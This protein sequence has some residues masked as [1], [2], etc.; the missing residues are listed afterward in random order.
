VDEQTRRLVDHHQVLVGVD[1]RHA[2]VG[3]RRARSGDL[4]LG[5]AHHR[6]R[7]EPV[8]LRP[9]RTVDEDAACLDQPLGLALGRRAAAASR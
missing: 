5:Q 1:D 7:G 2:E 4:R 9:C 8:G 6:A 3:R